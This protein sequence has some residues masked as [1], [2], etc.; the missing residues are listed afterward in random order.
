MTDIFGISGKDFVDLFPNHLHEGVRRASREYF[1]TLV[2]FAGSCGAAHLTPLP[3]IVVDSEDFASTFA[4][5]IEELSWCLRIANQAGLE[6]AV[7]GHTGSN[8]ADP[9]RAECVVK[10]VPGLA[11]TLDLGHLIAQGYIRAAANPLIEHTSHVHAR[12]ASPGRLQASLET[13][14]IDFRDLL[15]RLAARGYP[16]SYIIESVWI[17]W[18]HCN[19]VDNV[20]EAILLRGVLE[21][22]VR[23]AA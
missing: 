3:G 22:D 13:N 15:T 23:I 9:V 7:E 6:F 16:G 12:C 1:H 8:I 4:L 17:D 19:E 18:E 2:D 21:T 10:S 14:T 5:C 11:L 20:G